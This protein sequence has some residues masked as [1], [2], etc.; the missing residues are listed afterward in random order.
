MGRA[1]TLPILRGPTHEESA[2][3]FV[4]RRGR[5]C[6]ARIGRVRWREH[7]S[8][9]VQVADVGKVKVCKSAGSNVAGEFTISRTALGASAGT[10]LATATVQPG[11]C[12]VVAED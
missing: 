1:A 2:T 10:A 12:V 5:R 6:T 3:Q 9:R 4:L 8:Q 11:D 7:V